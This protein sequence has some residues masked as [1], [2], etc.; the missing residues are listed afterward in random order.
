MDPKHSIIKGLHCIYFGFTKIELG[1][2]FGKERR[3][4]KKNLNEELPLH[5]ANS[6]CWVIF[7]AFVVV[8]WFF[9]S[10]VT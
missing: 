1:K 9:N 5:W 3:Q 4:F 7:H 2:Y 6:A 8:C 10:P